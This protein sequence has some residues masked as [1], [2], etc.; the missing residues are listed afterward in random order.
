LLFGTEFTSFT[1]MVRIFSIRIGR[2]KLFPDR[3]WSVR[4]FVRFAGN[5]SGK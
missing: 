2:L 1:A 4:I 3:M 5:L